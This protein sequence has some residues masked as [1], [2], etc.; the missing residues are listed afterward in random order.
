MSGK[1][2]I[3]IGFMGTGKSSVGQVLAKRIGRTWIDTDLEV[4]RKVNKSISELFE[5]NGEAC[6]RLWEKH[7]L[8]EALAERPAVITTGG[9]IVLD[10]D[11]V[12][13]ITDSGWV[14]ALDASVDELIKRL[15]ANTS[16]PLLSGD[17]RERVTQLKK[18]RQ[19]AYDFADFHLDTS[20]LTPDE[21]SD[22]IL[23]NWKEITDELGV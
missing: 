5:E 11:N 2:L 15:K 19:G 14:V 3:I 23:R 6:F 7:V 1:H 21:V 13:Q 4:E 8:I 20:G 9:G 17:V 16:R 18:K 10:Q 12:K 22:R